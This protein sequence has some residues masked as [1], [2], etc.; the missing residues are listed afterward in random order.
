MR[1]GMKMS[2]DDLY[3][4][5]AGN[6]SAAKWTPDTMPCP[7]NVQPISRVVEPCGHNGH[8]GHD[9]SGGL[10]CKPQSVP[11]TPVEVE[12]IID[13]LKAVG[14]RL[15]TVE[16][17]LRLAMLKMNREA[18]AELAVAIDDAFTMATNGDTARAQ[19]RRLLNDPQ[20]LEAAK[21]VWPRLPPALVPVARAAPSAPV[22]DHAPQWLRLIRDNCPLAPEDERL[23]NGSLAMRAPNEALEAAKRYVITWKHAASTES[24][25]AARDNAGR[26]AANNE[27]RGGSRHAR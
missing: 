2:L 10:E 19:C 15:G 27:L 23:L 16:V 4:R 3:Q 9:F 6:N 14:R 20:A 5:Y 1:K 7:P 25:E 26:R 21:A 17:L 12:A 8:H 24:R 13:G 11:A 18:A 22:V